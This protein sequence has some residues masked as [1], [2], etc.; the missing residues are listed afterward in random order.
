M[1]RAP[2]PVTMHDRRGYHRWIPVLY[3]QRGRRLII[4]EEC[5]RCGTMMAE[6]G[7]RLRHPAPCTAP[8]PPPGS[9]WPHADRS[10][11]LEHV[12][13]LLERSREHAFAA[14][15]PLPPAPAAE[16]WW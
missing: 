15:A 16:P 12:R 6:R 13:A 4:Y 3:E 14:G 11:V 10:T 5:Q 7:V 8:I 1:N 2:E 9:G